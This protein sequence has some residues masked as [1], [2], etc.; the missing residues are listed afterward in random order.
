MSEMDA[1]LISD[2]EEEERSPSGQDPT[3]IDNNVDV[4]EQTKVIKLKSLI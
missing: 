3:F 4:T 1:D 2:D